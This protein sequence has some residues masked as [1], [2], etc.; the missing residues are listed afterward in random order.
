M[1]LLSVGQHK[2]KYRGINT[3]DH[4]ESLRNFQ[5]ALFFTEI[6]GM[7]MITLLEKKIY[8]VYNI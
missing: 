7:V 4:K 8:T 6:L 2:N 5:M 3:R 1:G